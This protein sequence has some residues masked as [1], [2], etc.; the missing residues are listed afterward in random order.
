[1]PRPYCFGGARIKVLL[2]GAEGDCQFRDVYGARVEIT[3]R[4]LSFL[5][6]RLS[7]SS[8]NLAFLSLVLRMEDAAPRTPPTHTAFKSRE[9]AKRVI[10]AGYV[11]GAANRKALPRKYLE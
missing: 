1:M 4:Y 6:E 5:F 2:G 7:F 9:R 10:A 3:I 8:R 11:L